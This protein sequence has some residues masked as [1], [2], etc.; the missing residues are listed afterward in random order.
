MSIVYE[1]FDSRIDRPLAI[2]VLRE[3]LARDVNARQRFLREARAA[4]GLSHPNIVTVFDVGQNDGLPF[5]AMEHLSGRT[6]GARLAGDD[7]PGST[8]TVLKIALQLASAL[9]YAH[10]HGVIHRDLKPANIHFDSDSGLVKIMDFGI[11]AIDRPDSSQRKTPIVGTPTHMAPEQLLGRGDDARS[12]LYSLGV[13]LFELLTGELPFEGGDTDAVIEQVISHSTRPLKPLQHDTPRELVELVYRLMAREPDSR[14]ASARQVVEELEEIR[15]GMQRG[16]LQSV[17]RRSRL[18]RW[19][20]SIG[21]AVA[22]VLVFG[23]SHVYRSQ[24]GAIESA[25]FGFGDA[26]ASLVAQETAEALILE[27]TTALSIMVSDFSVNPQIEHL[28]VADAAGT[29]QASTNPF[30]QGQIVPEPMG[31][32]VDRQSGSVRLTRSADG[33]LQFSVPVRFQARRVGEVHLGL[34]GSGLDTT[35]A[36]TLSMLALVF[37]ITVLVVALG[38]AWIIRRQQRVL[39]RLTWGLKRLSRGQIDFRLEGDRRDEF[40][41]VYRQFNRLALRLEEQHLLA[42][43]R[44]RAG[45]EDRVDLDPT[46]LPKN[47]SGQPDETLDISELDFE[48]PPVVPNQAGLQSGPGGD[49]SAPDEAPDDDHA[50][51]DVESTVTRLHSSRRNSR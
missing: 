9:D 22:L 44:Q 33:L 26:L 17:R 8:E 42:S 4:G 2:K 47:V 23:L 13:V 35:A 20:L 27:D 10:R 11:A 21:A 30:L 6:L 34:D 28:H 37:S 39:E 24:T 46:G 38:V 32:E 48:D 36:T 51:S 19:P 1:G 3:R 41:K 14:P 45:N 43:G 50:S 16:L 7:A 5:L 31:T 18:W 12:D 29:V 15:S 40:S 25:T 49:R